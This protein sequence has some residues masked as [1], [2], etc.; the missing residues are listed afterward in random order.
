ML[1][2]WG[3]MSSINVQKVAWTLGEL[4]LAHEQVDVGGRFGGLD[5][6]EFLARNPH[7]RIPVIDDDGTTV[8]ESN[9][10]VRYL[11][12]R[13]SPDGLWPSSAAARAKSD[14]WMEWSATSLQPAFMEFFWSWYRTPATM[15]DEERNAALLAR[16]HSAF[17]ALEPVLAGADLGRLTMAD[18]P[19]GSLLYRYFTLEIARPPLPRLEAWY[20]KLGGRPA[21]RE[22]VMRPYDELKGRLAF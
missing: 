6:P 20:A 2:L 15:R 16:A 8:W 5:S 14:Q 9:A 10:I 18:I 19:I 17:A 21:Y 11:C 4:N 7:G 13:Y 3:R 1:K 12:A 22:S